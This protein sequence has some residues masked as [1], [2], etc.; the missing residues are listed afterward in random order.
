MSWPNVKLGDLGVISAGGTPSRS[1]PQYWGNGIKWLSI[2]DYKD[3]QVVEETTEQITQE[4]LDNSSAKLFEEGSVIISIFA[5]LG[6]VAILGKTMTTNQAIAGIQCNK[7]INNKYLM[8]CLKSK[9][10]EIERQSGGVA[11]KNIN[12]SILKSLEIP[13]PPLETQKQITAVLEKSDQLRKD[14]KQMEQELNSLAQSVFIDMFGDLRTNSLF[15]K[16]V[17]FDQVFQITSK[18]VDPQLTENENLPHIGPEH[19]TKKTG[20]ILPHQT[21]KEDGLISGKFRFNKDCVLFSK[22]RPNLKKTA[23]PDFSGLCSADMYPLNPIDGVSTSEFI[24]G[25]ILSPAFDGYLEQLPSRANIPKINR[26]ELA[27]F[28]CHLPDYDL[29]VSYSNKL[30]AIKVLIQENQSQQVEIEKGFNA[31]VQRAFKG[32]LNLN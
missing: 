18:L 14:C 22:I 2:K 17:R 25:L 28:E 3:F 31:L 29:Q 8:Y 10:P 27:A 23:I 26:K 30:N 24:W 32:E 20:Q 15:P 7:Q 6:R 21:A 5:T 11:Q 9:L 12:L 13:L 1:K 16:K 19:I 4:G